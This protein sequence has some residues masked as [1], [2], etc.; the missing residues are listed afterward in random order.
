MDIQALSIKGLF[1]LTPTVFKDDRGYFFESYNKSKL[2]L[3]LQTVH[4]IQDNESFSHYGTIRGLHFQ[5]GEFA[6][7]KLVRVIT[8]SVLDV[9]VDV[10]PNSP[11]FGHYESVVLTAENKKQFF[12]PRGFA[13]GFSVLSETALFSYKC[14]NYYSKNHE[15]GILFN[16]PELN[17]DWQIPIA[18][19]LVSEKDLNLKTLNIL[20]LK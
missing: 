14:D 5:T 4:F 2:P 7:A 15:S 18:K 16:D 1:V 6:Q 8:G 12:I 13:H 20:G 19:T 9:A 10:R 3:E 11:T 17:I